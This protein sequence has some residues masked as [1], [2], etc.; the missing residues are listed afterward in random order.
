MHAILSRLVFVSAA[1]FALVPSCATNDPVTLTN[2]ATT[3]AS[4]LTRESRA[5]LSSLYSQNPGARALGRRA[6]AIVVFPSITRAGFVFG[7][8]AGNGTMFRNDGSVVAH[9][10]TTSASWGLQ[11]GI[12]SFG[13]A[14][15][16]M[17]DDAIRNINRS[18]GWEVGSSP[19][20]VVVDRGMA[21]SLSTTSL[22]RSTYAV[23]FDQ[24]GLMAGLGLQGSKITRIN[25]GR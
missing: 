15:F 11:A 6:R 14:L 8:Q 24:K 4:Q 22:N 10:Q 21:G 13:Y 18:G 25:P 12:Q 17:D 23:F 2:A 3:S 7:G 9:F 1:T 19:S 20:L 16:L 5:A